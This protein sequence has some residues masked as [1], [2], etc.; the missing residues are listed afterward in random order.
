MT[1][2]LASP[3]RIAHTIIV[4]LFLEKFCLF[5]VPSETSVFVKSIVFGSQGEG[6]RLFD[7]RS[8]LRGYKNP[9]P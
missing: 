5:V 8:L 4:S 1:L 7:P 3:I 6:E 2:L 9:L